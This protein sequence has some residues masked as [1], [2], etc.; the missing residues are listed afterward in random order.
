M[1]A[2]QQV[3]GCSLAHGK[4]YSPLYIVPLYSPRIPPLIAIDTWNTLIRIK[5]ALIWLL[6]S[7]L[8]YNKDYYSD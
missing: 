5:A 6:A 2:I 1:L 7:I 8:T 3:V 4:S